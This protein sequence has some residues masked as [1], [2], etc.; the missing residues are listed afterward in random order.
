MYKKVF[1]LI[2]LW[3]FFKTWVLLLLSE[4]GSEYTS[5]MSRVSPVFTSGSCSWDDSSS[6]CVSYITVTVSSFDTGANRSRYPGLSSCS[7]LSPQGKIG[8]V[9]LLTLGLLRLSS[10]FSGGFWVDPVSSLISPCCS[11]DYLWWLLVTCWQ[12]LPL[13]IYPHVPDFVLRVE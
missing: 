11:L 8:S 12:G 6:G 5:G 1:S 13:C 2:A 3:L 7:W 9:L 10:G 4:S